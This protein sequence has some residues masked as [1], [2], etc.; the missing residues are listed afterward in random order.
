MNDTTHAGLD[1]ADTRGIYIATRNVLT[2]HLSGIAR[3]DSIGDAR[4][5][6]TLAADNMLTGSVWITTGHPANVYASV[7][8]TI[9]ASRVNQRWN[10]P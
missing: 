1:S 7:L 8:E 3:F 6:A 5:A 10:K 2:G 9:P 4:E